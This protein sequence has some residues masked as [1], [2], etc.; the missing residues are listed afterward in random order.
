[1]SGGLALATV[2][3]ATA[4]KAISGST[5]AT[6]ATFSSVAI[7]EMDRYGYRRVLST[8]VVASVGTLGMLLPPSANLIV[9]GM[10]TEQSIG[11]LF[12][13]G[14]LPGIVVAI[15][16]FLVVYLWCKIDPTAA[17]RGPRSGWVERW[18]SLS[19]VA[20]PLVIFAIVIGGLMGGLFT[21]TEAGAVG[22]ISVVCLTMLKKDLNW[23]G[24]FKS[25]CESVRMG[26]M[27]LMLVAGS[28]VFGHF[29]A[30]SQIPAEM[31]AW[32]AGLP[33][34]RNIILC[35]I[36]F[37]YL[38]GGSIMDDVA[39]MILATPIFYP[40]VMRLGFDP[41]F[42]AIMLSVTLMVGV[43]IP[44]VAVSV[45]LVKTIT[46][47]KIGTIYKGITPFLSAL[48]LT[49]ILLFVFPRLA[50]LLPDLLMK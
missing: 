2:M 3:G 19:T 50:T 22:S 41:I 17:P 48:F 12:I 27:V 44:P 36:L 23:K 45:F 18:K 46:G 30:I 49:A 1:M 39:F 15:L 47:E 35:V 13:A 5:L 32:T 28:V 25:L 40:V 10:I 20:W 43:I 16:F 29:I 8:G 21:P 31:A 42:F 33:V 4:F 26:A 38:L 34:H 9:L 14:A 7:P 6:S 24:F 11:R 37:I